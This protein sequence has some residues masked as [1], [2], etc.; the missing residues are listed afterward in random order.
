[1]TGFGGSGPIPLSGSTETQQAAII[2]PST[3]AKGAKPEE[4]YRA[5]LEIAEHRI[6]AEQVLVGGYTVQPGEAAAASGGLS[7]VLA[8]FDGLAEQLFTRLTDVGELSNYMAGDAR[9]WRELMR[10]ARQRSAAAKDAPRYHQLT[11]ALAVAEFLASEP[12][13]NAEREEFALT[14]IGADLS[15]DKRS[16]EV[17]ANFLTRLAAPKATPNIAIC[18]RDA[19]GDVCGERVFAA[20]LTEAKGECHELFV[21]TL[22]AERD[23]ANVEVSLTRRAAG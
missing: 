21:K 12:I 17:S 6:G 11:R 3:R 1:M 16:V 5:W 8:F 7:S 22:A 23:I 20:P 9:R 13:A 14:D 15:D 10:A 19:N 2:A 4:I 18:L